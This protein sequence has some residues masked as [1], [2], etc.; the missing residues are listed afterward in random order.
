M[1]QMSYFGILG[2]PPRIGLEGGEAGF[3]VGQLP[4]LIFDR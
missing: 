1:Y 4:G 3:G 2:Q